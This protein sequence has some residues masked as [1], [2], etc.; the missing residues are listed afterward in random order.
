M[1][2]RPCTGN[3]SC[4]LCKIGKALPRH[5]FASLNDSDYKL[6]LPELVSV[7]TGLV[8]CWHIGLDHPCMVL[9]GRNSRASHSVDL[10]LVVTVGLHIVD[11]DAVEGSQR[12]QDTRLRNCHWNGGLG[13][14]IALD[15]SHDP[16]PDV[17]SRRWPSEGLEY[18]VLMVVG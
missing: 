2:E 5:T 11:H 13:S 6:A 17:W 1:V 14:A 9:E 8:D 16:F 18:Q 12:E 10:D 15:E 4:S 3:H 7:A